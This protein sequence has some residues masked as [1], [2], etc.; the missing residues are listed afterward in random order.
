MK[1]GEAKFD[2]YI[3]QNLTVLAVETMTKLDENKAYL[4]HIKE[5]NVEIISGDNFKTISIEIIVQDTKKWS[6]IDTAT[7]ENFISFI[8]YLAEN[9]D[10]K[11]NHN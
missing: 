5:K 10:Y 3:N 11:R 6:K 7:A 8:D 2:F 9:A 1:E 4:Y